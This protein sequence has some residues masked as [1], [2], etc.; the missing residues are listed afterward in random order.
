M[1]QIGSEHRADFLNYLQS[2]GIGH[3]RKVVNAA[4]LQP[5][6]SE[7][8]SELVGKVLVA[9]VD[10]AAYPVLVSSDHY[11]L[12]GHN[13]WFGSVLLMRPVHCIEVGCSITQLLSLT[14]AWPKA[15]RTTVEQVEKVYQPAKI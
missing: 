6:Q 12:D 9:G 11:V 8:N 4:T 15:G 5:T 13:R 14:L 10:T 2:F 3:I 7:I 1:P